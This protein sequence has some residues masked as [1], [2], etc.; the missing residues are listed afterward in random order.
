ML[1]MQNEMFPIEIRFSPR[2][3]KDLKQLSKRYPSIRADVTACMDTINI[4]QPPGDEIIG[5][6]PY[7]AYKVRIRN[8]DN[9]KGAS[10]GYR[11][12]YFIFNSTSV[13]AIIFLLTI[14]S[15]NDQV[16][17]RPDLIVRLIDEMI[18]SL[19]Q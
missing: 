11:L 9:N 2:L 15:K 17:V 10:A 6:H 1:S 4:H 16:D 7:K 8:S 13:N 5:T 12:I 19:P 3:A 18:G 14:Y